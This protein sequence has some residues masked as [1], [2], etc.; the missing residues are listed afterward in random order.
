MES[1]G[2]QVSESPEKLELLKLITEPL[3][4]GGPAR[5]QQ[6][7]ET[8]I[9]QNPS[10]AKAIDLLA[11][12]CQMQ[13][14]LDVAI[15][16]LR[17]AVTIAPDDW[18]IHYNLG[19]MLAM[20]TQTHEAI[21]AYTRALAL[22]PDAANAHNNLGNLFQ[23][24]GRLSDAKHHFEEAL[25]FQPDSVSAHNNVGNLLLS[26]G[27]IDDAIECFRHAL[28]LRPD[29]AMAYSNILLALNS[30]EG[31][32]PP[33][34]LI[35]HREFGRRFADHLPA[36]KFSKRNLKRGERLRIGYL[37]ADFRSHSVAF[38]LDR[39]L[40]HHDRSRFLVTC[41]SNVVQP[42]AMTQR[43]R[44]HVEQWRDIFT[45]KD[46]EA[47]QLI[48]RD[49]IDILI[50]L[51]GHT[52]RSRLLLLGRRPAPVQVS[53]LGYPNTTG[54][55]QADYLITDS[56]IAPDDADRAYV[57]KVIRLPDSFFCYFGP[58]IGVS[59][60]PPPVLSKG[61]ITFGVLTNWVK[62]RPAMM[63]L[64]VKILAREE[65]SRIILKANSLRDEH[66]ANEVRSFFVSRGIAAE[67]IEIHGWTDFLAYMQLMSEIDIG[68][69]TFP[70]N[71]HTTTCHQ[72]W[73]GVPV[74][75]RV[76][77]TH[78]SRMGLS[79]LSSLGLQDM[80]A[81]TADEYV[82]IAVA[83]AG[84]PEKL[85]DLRSAMRDRW[86]T[87]GLLD[88]VRFTRNLEQAYLQMWQQK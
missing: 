66:L 81:R 52:E 17:R 37:S 39:I 15:Q 49:Q 71:G 78:A 23:A 16:W 29:Y 20:A 68:L 10:N 58:E 31:Y 65:G 12:I 74:V 43:M 59:V 51:G 27:R 35:E 57:E 9:A 45:L 47:A 77:E 21:A 13:G 53:Y 87:S 46:D 1:A 6:V 34:L 24:E 76:G 4:T 67:R 25:R 62:V 22:K 44:R 40:E 26:L 38:F 79:V 86:K 36:I 30:H 88:G 55:T 75:T 11:A 5:A 32:D 18:E 80:A 3:R 33:A 7:L 48:A 60:A 61:H 28:A 42:D 19:L 41:Y 8:F 54:M 83:L 56:R 14:K 85:K 63:E 82:D 69:D 84:K 50:D 2:E 72:L 64:W 73:M 70:F